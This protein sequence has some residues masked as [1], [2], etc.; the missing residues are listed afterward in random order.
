MTDHQDSSRAPSLRNRIN[1]ST[2]NLTTTNIIVHTTSNTI[3]TTVIHMVTRLQTIIRGGSL[4]ISR[5]RS[6]AWKV[7]SSTA[8]F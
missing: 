1:N 2:I 5:Q 4:W 3:I 6:R 8:I 7:Q